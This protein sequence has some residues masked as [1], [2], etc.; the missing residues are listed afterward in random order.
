MAPEEF[1]LGET[2]DE[3]TTVFTMGRTAA[4]LMSDGSLDGD[5]FKGTDTQYD[6]MLR[7]CAKHP[8]DRIQSIAELHAAWTAAI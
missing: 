5:P 1:E 7:A 4:V 6:V 8:N 3:R 2:I